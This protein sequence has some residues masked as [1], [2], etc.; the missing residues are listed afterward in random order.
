MTIL[1]TLNADVQCI[2]HQLRCPINVELLNALDREQ[3][4]ELHQQLSAKD[5][6]LMKTLY[7]TNHIEMA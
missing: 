1:R 5:Y 2:G 6:Q 7:N 3:W 4:Q